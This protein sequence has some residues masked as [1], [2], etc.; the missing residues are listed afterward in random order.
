M[1][2]RLLLVAVLVCAAS[3]VTA[4][5]S[6]PLA[7]LWSSESSFGPQLRGELRVVR[8]GSRWTATI[9]DAK[10]SFAVR[11]DDVRFAFSNRG[12][13]RGRIEENN[14]RGFWLQPQGITA[15]APNASGASQSFASPVVLR[16]TAAGVWRGEVH[17]LQERFTLYLRIF[18]AS[19]GSLLGAFRNPE[20]GS[21]GG[22]MQFKVTRAG[23]VVSFSAGDTR[24]SAKLMSDRLQMFWPDMNRVIELTR[25]TPAEMAGFFPRPPGEKYMYRK[26]P[27]IGDG[28]TTARASDVGMDEDILTKLI[29][30]LI[31]ADPSI[32]R[33]ALMHS[34]L[35]AH[36]GK[37]VL[38]EYF[39]GSNRN[40]P[41]D[42][43]S[44]GKTF[45]SVMLGAVMREGVRI[46]PETPVYSL[47]AAKG[48]FA[49]PDP[50]KAQITLA[51]LLTHTSGLACN[52]NDSDSP[53]N[54][55]T[56]QMQTQQPDWWKYT[57]DLPMAHDPGTRYAYC[58]AG[59]NLA[60][61]ALTTATRTWLPE[62]FE[63]TVARP[64][65]FGPYYWNLMPTGEGYLGGGAYLLPRDLL[66]V[67]QAYLDGGVW[68]GHRIV[69]KS[70]IATSTAPHVHVSPATTGIDPN[71]F[72]NFYGE[73]DDGYAWHLS[74]LKLGDRTYRCYAATGNGGQLLIVVPDV[75]LAVVFTAGNYGQGGIWS[76]F[77]DQIVP[78]DIIAA[79]R[80]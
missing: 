9:A 19:D 8:D 28:W 26:P 50:R 15:S 2:R 40:E 51:H 78:N 64:L 45:A 1:I 47:L 56:M 31:D 52:D 59:I 72:G 70:W 67:G 12:A 14:I 80:K 58:S 62:L 63:R 41:H 71:D 10:T 35:V 37:L 23:D 32:R 60:G 53:G 22:A 30:R 27:A 74:D 16:R 65:Q 5:A 76:K 73:A 44:A 7:G 69:D 25:R 49:N 33:A 46:V 11:G 24:L 57:L 29:Q 54:E 75:D 3:R 38:E 13:F 20:Q 61:A 34:I 42:L 21:N 66:K 55:G 48:P 4:Q 17:P 36:H 79:I 6:D 43:R 18:A 77:K 68:H 39:F